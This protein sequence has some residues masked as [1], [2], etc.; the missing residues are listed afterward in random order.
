MQ[1][2]S[3]E[4]DSSEKGEV[5]PDLNSLLTE[6]SDVFNEP[7]HLPPIRPCDH[8]IQLKPGSA[9]IQVK[10]YRYPHIHKKMR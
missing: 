10:P 1:L 8:M 3:L 5:S 2:Y 4:G 6:F 9:P 7:K